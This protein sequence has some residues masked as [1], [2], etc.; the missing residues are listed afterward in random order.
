MDVK[1]VKRLKNVT[2]P[3]KGKRGCKGFKK[4]EF[5]SCHT[6]QMCDSPVSS[7]IKSHNEKSSCFELVNETAIDFPIFDPKKVKNR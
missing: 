2:A 7:K 5:Q 4:D 6:I 3:A 1:F